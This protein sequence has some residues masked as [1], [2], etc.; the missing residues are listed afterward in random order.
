MV[1]AIYRGSV[2]RAEIYKANGYDIA[3]M[4]RLLQHSSAAVTQQYIGTEPQ[5]TEAAIQNHAQLLSNRDAAQ[6]GRLALFKIILNGSP[7][8]KA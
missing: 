2:V 8:D 5:R 4:Q 1:C 3:L 6:I 7:L